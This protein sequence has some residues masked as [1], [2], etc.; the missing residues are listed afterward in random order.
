[1]KFMH[2]EIKLFYIQTYSTRKILILFLF[3]PYQAI[4]GM[5][6][7]QFGRMLLPSIERKKSW[8]WYNSFLV[9]QLTDPISVK[10]KIIF[11]WQKLFT[12]PMV[13]RSLS[14]ICIFIYVYI[15]EN[16]KFL[17]CYKKNMYFSDL[18]MISIIFKVTAMRHPKTR[19]VIKYC[20]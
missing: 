7:R 8:S 4:L 19:L 15:N 1:M 17:W 16:T 18:K 20:I 6:Q 10:K 12:V 13:F 14:N 3:V 11:W 9:W 5:T 2:I